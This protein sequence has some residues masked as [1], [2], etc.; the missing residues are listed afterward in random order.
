MN[1]LETRT[2]LRSRPWFMK[3][4]GV[5]MGALAFHS[6][7]GQVAR[8]STDPMAARAPHFRPRWR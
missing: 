6:L 4:C 5:G 8:A 1:P 3:E 7:M 2:R